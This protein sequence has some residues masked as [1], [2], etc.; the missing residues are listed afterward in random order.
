MKFSTFA[1]VITSIL[2]FLNILNG[3]QPLRPV[4]NSPWNEIH[5]TALSHPVA[6]PAGVL[7]ETG[8]IPGD[9]IGVFT[10][11]GLCAGF[12]TI[13]D[14]DAGV[15]VIAFANDHT[16]GVKDGFDAGELFHFKLFSLQL[17]Q[18]FDL[19]VEFDDTMPNTGQ[20]EVQGISSVTS[21]SLV[22]TSVNHTT[23]N[24]IAVYPNPSDGVFSLAM[25]QWP[26]DLVIYLTDASGR[27]LQTV[28]PGKKL[29]GSSYRFQ[30]SELRQGVYF[31]K[32]VSSSLND[33]QK[34]VIR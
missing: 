22:P 16:T 13:D 15:A 18:E 1:L 30:L 6:F 19:W 34:V 31:L 10:P 9:I 2:F 25:R 7:S 20:F 12:T 28:F 8:I 23:D 14:V 33:V 21:V 26:D 4:V 29:N 11:E 24:A 3:Q 17:N 27:N 5:Y 32:M